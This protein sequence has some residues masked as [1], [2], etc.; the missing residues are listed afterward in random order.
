[1]PS[2][3]AIC[4]TGQVFARNPESRTNSRSD[5]VVPVE[6]G[7]QKSGRAD[8]S[9][10]NS[11]SASPLASKCGTLYLPI[12]VG[13]RLSSSGTQRRESSSVDQITC[14]SPA[15]FAARAIAPACASSFSGEKCAQKKVTQNA[16]W[17]TTSAPSLASAW[18]FVGSDDPW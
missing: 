3:A 13:M 6:R 11:W 4:G 5:E 10:V 8:P 18:A 17:A 1:L 16:P 15:F 7:E 9:R 12:N 14:W 2:E